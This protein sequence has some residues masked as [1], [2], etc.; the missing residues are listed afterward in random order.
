MI[1]LYK[2]S[3]ILK[4]RTLEAHLE[5]FEMKNVENVNPKNI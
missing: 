4:L 1:I 3:G 2:S 5:K